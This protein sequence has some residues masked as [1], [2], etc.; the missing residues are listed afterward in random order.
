MDESNEAMQATLGDMLDKGFKKNPKNF[1]DRVSMGDLRKEND[2]AGAA[3]EYGAALRIKE[4]ATIQS[5]R[6]AVEN[7]LDKERSVESFT[8]N[9]STLRSQ[10]RN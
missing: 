3:V 5:K 2:L 7:L 4:D 1:D 10:C 6:Q 8:V 9:K